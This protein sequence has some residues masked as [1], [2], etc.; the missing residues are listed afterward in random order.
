M[1][2]SL[3]LSLSLLLSYRMP[4]LSQYSKLNSDLILIQRINSDTGIVV[5]NRLDDYEK[6]LT[7]A[8][9]TKLQ[10][11][12]IQTMISREIECDFELTKDDIGAPILVSSK[13]SEVSISHSNGYFA[14]FLSREIPVGIDVE[15]CREIPPS[16]TS[17]FL[18]SSEEKPWTNN[19]LS[20]IWGAKESYFK[21]MKGDVKDLR[22]EASILSISDTKVRLL[23]RE[24][25]HVF[26]LDQTDKYTLVYG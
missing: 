15:I 14:V 26:N 24:K 25:Q 2:S 19:E 18:N 1:L 10:N 22:K 3:L 8:G 9:K 21:K 16:G 5:L 17:Y 11:D 20:A 12:I 13:F 6:H 4:N 23:C 7:R